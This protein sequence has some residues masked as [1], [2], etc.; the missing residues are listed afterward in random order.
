MKLEGKTILVTGAASGVGAATADRAAREGASVI[1][2]DLD[3]GL[4]EE[5]TAKITGD[6]GVARWVRAD[7]GDADDCRRAISVADGRLDGL[8]NNAAMP[9]E[10][11]Q[12]LDGPEAML[13]RM[14]QVN[15]KGAWFLM[16]EAVEALV[17]AQGAVVN[18][19]SYA[20]DHACPDLGFYAMTKAALR[21]LT[22]TAAVELALRGVRVNAV[23]PGFLDTP[24]V[25]RV[26]AR[27]RPDDPSAAAAR[28]VRPAPMRRYGRPE[29]VAGPIVFLLGP[30]S[31]FITGTVLAVDGGMDAV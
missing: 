3:D 13:D 31:S 10:F 21:S 28:V 30:D 4:L 8:V 24:M 6:G 9:G 22:Q 12:V 18:T 7:I 27:M 5:V 26:E 15:V 17:A 16:R 19:L 11:G 23:A 14:V 25:R 29:E 1:L 20:A 2:V